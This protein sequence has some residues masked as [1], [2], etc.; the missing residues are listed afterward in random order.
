MQVDYEWE[1]MKVLMVHNYYRSSAPSGEDRVF[2]NEVALLR[3]KG[4]D[5]VTYERHNDEAYRITK[6]KLAHDVVWNKRTFADMDHLIRREKPDIAHFHNTWYMISPSAYYACRTRN[7]PIVQTLHNFRMFCANGLL[8]R[9]DR[10]CEEC[11]DTHGMRSAIYGC[12]GG[13]RLWT[14]PVYT[15]QRYHRNRGTWYDTVD[16]YITLNNFA[17]D[18]FLS[19]GIDPVKLF[20]K[21]NFAEDCGVERRNID[22]TAIYVGRLT[23]EKGVGVLVKA[24]EHLIKDGVRLGLNII[25]DGILKDKIDVF[26]DA[27]MQITGKK[28]HSEVIQAIKQADYAILPSICYE[29]LPLVL[30]ESFACG[31]PVVASRIGALPELVEDGK[32]GLLFEPGNSRD[33]ASKIKWMLENKDTCIEMGKNARKVYEEKY[34]AEKNFKMLMDIYS[35]VLKKK[36]GKLQKNEHLFHVSKGYRSGTSVASRC[37]EFDDGHAFLQGVN[38]LPLDIAG[39]FHRVVDRLQRKDGGYF[40]FAN[41][42]VVMES[43]RDVELRDALNSAAGV[44][45]DGMGTAGALKYLSHMF[46]GR[47]RGADL[48]LRLCEYA[49]KSKLKVFFYGNTDKTL[50]RLSH[51]LKSR[52]PGLNIVG[53]YS[54][55]FRELN[56]E[57]DDR[58]VSTINKVGPDI[59]FVSLGAPK[60]EKWMAG[61]QGRINAV[62]LGVGAAFDYIAGNLKEAPGW[63][64]N[65]YLEWLYRLPQQPR[66]TIYRM[67]LLPEFLIRLFVQRFWK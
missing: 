30:V 32:T 64:Q 28:H 36:H 53:A 23:T 8:L 22:R 20:V 34:T 59:L 27:R 57:E 7:V 41:I 14:L 67:A 66:K 45:A 58:I 33:L 24:Y 26:P 19:Y 16:A 60:Q 44:F 9:K 43:H 47:V 63:M 11:L 54:P 38:F 56:R 55:P 12:Y 17:K 48:M 4:I 35:S 42:H 37:L 65:H 50:K 1:T 46:K 3:S 10:I 5:V 61:H 29:M 62:Q 31:R 2:E 52:Y 25:G 49:A 18:K 15:A 13:S 6:A 21:P 40:C 39:G 51:V